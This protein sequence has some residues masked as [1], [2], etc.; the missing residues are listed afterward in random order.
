MVLLWFGKLIASD[1]KD[2]AIWRARTAQSKE[3]LTRAI[4][5]NPAQ[6]ARPSSPQMLL[7]AGRMNA[8]GYFLSSMVHWKRL[9]CVSEVRPLG[10]KPSCDREISSLVAP[11]KASRFGSSVREFTSML[12]TSILN[13]ASV[14]HGRASFIQQLGRM[15]LAGPVMPQDMQTVNIYQPNLWLH[16]WR[17]R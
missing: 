15:R 9:T 1:E 12:A 2:F 4:I 7:T 10:G 11:C 3:E 13:Y 6:P 14:L 16:I 8:E 17:A 5:K